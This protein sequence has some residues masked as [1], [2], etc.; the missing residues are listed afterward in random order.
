[1]KC[2]VLLKTPK[3]YLDTDIVCTFTHNL[4]RQVKDEN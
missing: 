1:M 4:L 2:T 3:E